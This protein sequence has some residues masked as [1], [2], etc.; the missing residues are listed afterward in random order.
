MSDGTVLE[1]L[2]AVDSDPTRGMVFHVGAMADEMAIRRMI[3][4]RSLSRADV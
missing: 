2:R 4:M 3:Y 1:T